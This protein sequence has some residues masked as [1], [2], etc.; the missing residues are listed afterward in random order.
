MNEYIE[1]CL[2]F[3][4]TNYKKYHLFNNFVIFQNSLGFVISGVICGRGV[5]HSFDTVSS[6]AIPKS[7]HHKNINPFFFL[8]SL[9]FCCKT[10]KLTI[11]IMTHKRMTADIKLTMNR[12]NSKIIRTCP[13]PSLEQTEMTS[14]IKIPT[15]LLVTKQFV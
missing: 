5:T 4:C 7:A 9:T 12:Q 6:L 10:E 1:Y 11:F 8:N 15:Y 2:E 13:L 3:F 14:L